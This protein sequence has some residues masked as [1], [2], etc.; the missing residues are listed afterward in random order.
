[1][2]LFYQHIDKMAMGKSAKSS[3]K[4]Q[5][6]N[7]AVNVDEDATM[8]ETAPVSRQ[9]NV[10][11]YGQ[12]TTEQGKPAGYFMYIHRLSC[13]YLDTYRSFIYIFTLTLIERERINLGQAQPPRC[14][15]LTKNQD[16]LHPFCHLHPH[17]LLGKCLIS[18]LRWSRLKIQNLASYAQGNIEQL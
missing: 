5:F 8:E 12:Q 10:N 16:L 3:K 15:V 1:M 7:E 4:R 13:T 6:V 11:D 17:P 2:N 14:T 18:L 9:S